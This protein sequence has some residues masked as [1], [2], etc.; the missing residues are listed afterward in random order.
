M[1]VYSTD[2]CDKTISTNWNKL[3]NFFLFVFVKEQ[4]KGKEKDQE[5]SL[6]KPQI[7]KV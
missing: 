3:F 5:I 1:H 7:E 6:S 2:T 4:K